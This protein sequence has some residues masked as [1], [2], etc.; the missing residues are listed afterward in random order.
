[1]QAATAKGEGK[2]YHKVMAALKR[3]GLELAGFDAI[4]DAI[5]EE[6]KALRPAEGK[7]PFLG[8]RWAAQV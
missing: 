1:M 2:R 8:L 5:W 7:T 4:P 6:L 3:A